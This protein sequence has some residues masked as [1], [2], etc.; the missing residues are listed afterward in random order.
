MLLT[1]EVP[2]LL[3]L[4]YDGWEGLVGLQLSSPY[5]NDVTSHV[6]PGRLLCVLYPW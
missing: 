2:S 5:A 3:F 4:I 1:G 6:E